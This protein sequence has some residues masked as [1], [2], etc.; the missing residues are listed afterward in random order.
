MAYRCAERCPRDYRTR[1]ELPARDDWRLE[2]SFLAVEELDV[3]GFVCENSRM[4]Q[5]SSGW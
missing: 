4:G 3:E 1:E 5:E 2:S